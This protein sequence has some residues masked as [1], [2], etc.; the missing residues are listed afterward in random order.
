[1]KQTVMTSVYGV[2]RIGARDQILARLEE[3]FVHSPATVV[4]AEFEKD[5]SKSAMYV[6]HVASQRIYTVLTVLC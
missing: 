4:S 3:K 2:T 1:M 6:S 5:L